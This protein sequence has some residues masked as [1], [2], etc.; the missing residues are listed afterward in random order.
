VADR[1]SPDAAA[2]GAPAPVLIPGYTLLTA[3]D[4]ISSIVIAGRIPRIR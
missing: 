1:T 4:K 2:P 3:T